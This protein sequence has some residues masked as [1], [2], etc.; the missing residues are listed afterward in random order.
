LQGLERGKP[1][2]GELGR[3]KMTRKIAK[4]NGRPVSRFQEKGKG[5]GEKGGG[6]SVRRG[7]G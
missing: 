5:Q 4:K 7:R 6:Q 1:F 3:R 2:G